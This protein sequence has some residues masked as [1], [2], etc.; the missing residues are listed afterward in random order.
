MK[1]SN[2]M[3]KLILSC[4]LIQS[5]LIANQQDIDNLFS[6]SLEELMTI[7]VSTVA[8]KKENTKKTTA[9]V[10]VITASQL[11]EWGV[12]SVYEALSYLPGIQINETYMGYTAVTFRGVTPGLYNTK[13]L[14]MVNGHPVHERLF[15]SSH[16][17]YIPIEI[18]KKIEVVKTPSSILYGSNAISGV[19]NI[20]TKRKDDNS[21]VALRGG[22]HDHYYG[23][24]GLVEDGYTF[25]GSLKRDKGYNYNGTKDE[26]GND[27]NLDYHD[28]LG[29]FFADIYGDSWH[30]Q[31]AYFDLDEQKFGATPNIFHTG[32]NNQESFY[33]DINKNFLLNN[34]KLD[35]YLRYDNFKKDLEFEHF[36]TPSDSLIRAQNTVDRFS[37]KLQYSDQLLSDLS[38]IVGVDGEFDRTT[39]FLFVD[40]TGNILV[41]SSPFQEDHD[42]HTIAA[43]LQLD[44]TINKKLQTVLGLR[45]EN[46]SDYG[47]S[48]VFPKIGLTYEIAD[49]NYIKLIY[50]EAFRTPNY[51]EK[52]ADFA[53]TKGDVN[54]LPENIKTA[55][56]SYNSQINHNS[57]LAMTLFY[58]K[59]A[60]EITRD[61]NLQY[62]NAQGRSV[63]GVEAEYYLTINKEFDLMLNGSYMDG[64]YNQTD[65]KLDYIANYSSNAVISYNIMNNL[66]ISVSNQYVGAKEYNLNNG[67]SGEVDHYNLANAML[68]YK[69]NSS[70]WMFQVKNLLNENY[71]FPEQ[72]RKNIAELPGGAER[73]FYL[74]YKYLF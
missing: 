53:F 7:E 35:L 41:N 4:T 27:V 40:Q 12:H 19:I 55:E 13:V 24:A 62:I 32:A 51:Y 10:S 43:Y 26:S 21:L 37:A 9:V 50:S 44:Y 47:V 56:L 3:T 34:G 42:F 38:Y 5:V 71:F 68:K 61:S 60:N 28:N 66:K 29:N 70:T 15:G 20:I 54:L 23:F 65:E 49:D 58:S 25:A 1:N 14:F 72:V 22:S 30:I 39:G 45:V 64:K 2:T 18:I 8:Q 11:E 33:V 69:Y 59:L 67:Q 46:N 17:E 36:P 6:M 74:T 31:S 52:Y 57:S 48:K 63:Y 73:S 16:S